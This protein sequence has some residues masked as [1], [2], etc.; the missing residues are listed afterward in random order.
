MS[1]TRVRCPLTREREGAR[2]GWGFRGGMVKREGVTSWVGGTLRGGTL[3]VGV[4]WWGD[5]WM[6]ELDTLR[7]YV[8]GREYGRR[9]GGGGLVGRG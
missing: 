3:G 4:R 2:R 9:G 5:C 1:L 8:G 6:L 7:G